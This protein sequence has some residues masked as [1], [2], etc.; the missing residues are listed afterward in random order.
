MASKSF[1]SDSLREE[2]KRDMEKRTK[3]DREIDKHLEQA[4]N[5]VSPAT[6]YSV[7]DLVLEKGHPGQKKHMTMVKERYESADIS[8]D[9]MLYLLDVYE[10]KKE[11]LFEENG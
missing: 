11:E 9:D 2:L 5:S 4:M 10:A 7:M 3:L 8:L 1:I 6:I